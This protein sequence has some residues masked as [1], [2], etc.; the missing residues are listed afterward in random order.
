MRF[1]RDASPESTQSRIPGEFVRSVAALQSLPYV[2]GDVEFDDKHRVVFLNIHVDIPSKGPVFDVHEMEPVAILLP[3]DFPCGAPCIVPMR[4]DFPPVPHLVRGPGKRFGT[5]C[6]TRQSTADWWHGKTLEDAVLAAYRWLTDA[7]AGELVKSDDPFEPLVVD[8]SN[9][10]VEVDFDAAR[11]EACR[12][13]GVWD[14]RAREIA[15][16]HLTAV[17]FVIG[18]GN[19]PTRLWYQTDTQATPWIETPVGIDGV[20]RLAAVVG[21]DSRKVQYWIEKGGKRHNRVLTV[22]GVRRPKQVM[23]QV[24]SEEWVAF[25]FHRQNR[26]KEWT[27]TSHLV[28]RRFDQDL[29]RQ[30]SGFGEVCEPRKVLVVYRVTRL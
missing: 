21:L 15:V 25:D 29:A 20:L 13:G 12:H 24:D 17:R 27:V 8:G 6:L 30:V 2:M 16:P 4:H 7:A 26:D 11:K 5:I 23:G 3:D 22:F 19:V 18:P 14:T 1:G 9:P 28:L 10:V